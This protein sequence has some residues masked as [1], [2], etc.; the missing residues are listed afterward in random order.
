MRA[1]V[2]AVL[3]GL[4]GVAAAAAEPPA[5]GDPA[6]EVA[7]QYI[8]A[9]DGSPLTLEGLRGKV[10][11]L[12]FWATWC[13]P[14]IAAIPHLNRVAEEVAGEP[15]V[16]IAITDEAP[17][18]VEPF[19]KKREMTAWVARDR[20][21][22]TM[23]AY[24]V[25]YIPHTVVIGPD[26][27]VA[28][29]TSPESI[30]AGVLRAAAAGEALNLAVKRDIPVEIEWEVA[31]LDADESVG[32][33]ILHR[34]YAGG[35]GMRMAPGSGRIQG[36]GLGWR[37]LVQIGWVVENQQIEGEVPSI[38]EAQY[39]VSV[40]SPRAD[41]A[42]ARELLR[43]FVLR[44]LPL[45]VERGRGEREV[46][47]LTRRRDAEAP[48]LSTA[49]EPRFSG[50]RGGLELQHARMF[51]LARMVA[52]FSG[53]GLAADETGLDGRYDVKLEWIA[54]DRESLAEALAAYGLEVRRER[55][56]VDV[57]RIRE[58]EPAR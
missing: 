5:I 21:R 16:F 8:Q 6:P 14:C 10:V 25:R 55:R 44:V 51:D 31:V 53:G 58:R 2:V 28:A 9:P 23:R 42:A 47:V 45:E 54:G 48:A 56:E 17:E 18:R 37:T 36:D 13:G 4:I 34:S 32:H 49:E 52:G 27:R 22:A 29:V 43:E 7:L 30:T 57:L 38:E 11:V 19:L 40:R 12:E 26:G 24:G 39:R 20:E 33:V 15:V 3:L 35:A 46:L 41:D 50:R 1:S